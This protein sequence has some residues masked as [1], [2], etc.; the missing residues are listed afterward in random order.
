[1]TP[2]VRN[3]V[4]CLAILIGPLVGLAGAEWPQWRGPDGLGVA[5]EGER[6]PERW[7]PAGEGVRWQVEIPGEGIS[8]PVAADGQV[9]VSTA[10]RAPKQRL[11]RTLTR[12]A[13]AGLAIVAL[14][15][16]LLPNRRAADGD[17]G[18]A[19]DR[20]IILAATW[21][22]VLIALAASAAPESLFPEGNPGR[23][24]RN[25]GGGALLGLAAAFG[26]FARSSRWRLFGTVLTV[27]LTAWLLIGMPEGADDG[28][29]RVKGLQA[30]LLGL[31][32]ALWLLIGFL[33][34]RG[35]SETARSRPGLALTLVLLAALVF[36]PANYMTGLQR[37][38][39]SVDLET[40]EI[41]WTTTVL[42]GPAE[43]KG[44]RNSYATPTPAIDSDG[45]FAYF[46][47]GFGRVDLDGE[48]AWSVPL[49][50]YAGHTRYGAGSSPVLTDRA[51]IVVRESEH[52]HGGPPSW[53][54]AFDRETG[55]ELWRTDAPDAQDSY[56]TPLVYESGEATLIL[57]STWHALRAYDADNGELLWSLDHPLE[58][59]VTSLARQDDLLAVTGGAYGE[60]VLMVVRL[61]GEGL[62]TRPEILWQTNKGVATIASPV[63]YD[64]MVFTVTTPGIVFAHDGESGDLVWKKRLSGEHFASPIAGDGKVYAIS[65]EGATSVIATRPEPELLTVNEL[66]ESVFASP[67]VADG[68]LLIRTASR[69]YCLDGG[70][71][72]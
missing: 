27:G 14:L 20:R 66:E 46:G 38:L 18:G 22:F 32:L 13:V 58:Q 31:L 60:K 69:L 41:L 19:W 65:A 44:G 57:L 10:Y 26:W 67:A 34:S 50:G 52:D 54:G 64:G 48:L 68:C 11:Q 6:L 55:D 39:I 9:F 35:G 36:V 47:H 42:T 63:F 71:S 59:V 1:M 72:S 24:W 56:G 40:G 5:A 12:V 37:A 49:Q 8:S 2:S 23:A 43:K 21:L 45:V 25:S 28:A 17:S 62:E 51:I 29:D 7:G 16:T 15:L 4:V 3:V 30:A 61:E 53:I 33:R 70:S